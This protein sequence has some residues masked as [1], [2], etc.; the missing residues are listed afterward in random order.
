MMLCHLIA[1]LIKPV[2]IS[3]C[4]MTWV[5]LHVNGASTVHI[6]GGLSSTHSNA[7]IPATAWRGTALN[8]AGTSDMC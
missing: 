6:S 8:R 1:L 5:A 7:I 3:T 4:V 2:S